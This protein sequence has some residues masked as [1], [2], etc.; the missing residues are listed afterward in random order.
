MP[1]R[2]VRRGRAPDSELNPYREAWLSLTPPSASAAPGACENAS[3]TSRPSTM[4]K[5]FQSFERV[6]LEYLLISG[7]A[8]ILYGAATFSEDVDL[9]E[10]RL[11]PEGMPVAEI[12]THRRS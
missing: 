1:R 8:S 11:L 7:Q 4:R 3:R 9:W 6:G 10:G 12:R 2:D 5:L